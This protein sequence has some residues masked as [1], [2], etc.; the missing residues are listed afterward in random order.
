MSALTK[1]ALINSFFNLL[2]NQPYKKITVSDITN[3]CGVNRMTFY[4]HFKDLNDLVEKSFENLFYETMRESRSDGDWSVTYLNLFNVIYTKKEYVKKLYPEFDI[5]ELLAF[6]FPLASTMAHG[7][8]EQKIRNEFTESTKARLVH[9]ISCCMV[10]SFLEW[11]ES[12]M[13]KDP[14]ELVNDQ[15]ELFDAAVFGI[16]TSQEKLPK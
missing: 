12:D 1:K 15:K 6:I 10:G 9:A 8:V 13:T 14:Q 5:R 11:L 3:D 4:Y 7:V 2:K 16:L